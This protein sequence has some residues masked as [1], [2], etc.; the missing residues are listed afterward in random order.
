MQC[1]TTS[2]SLLAIE[3]RTL[4]IRRTSAGEPVEDKCPVQPGSSSADKASIAGNRKFLPDEAMAEIA[5]R[6]RTF[7][8][9]H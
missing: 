9:T 4:R 8:G 1:R 2:T 3:V 6:E 5:C 7:R